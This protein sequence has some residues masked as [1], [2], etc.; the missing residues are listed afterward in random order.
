MNRQAIPFLSSGHRPT[1][2]KFHRNVLQLSPDREWYIEAS[3][4]FEAQ[5]AA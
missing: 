1:L 4:E 5:T 2:L 3:G